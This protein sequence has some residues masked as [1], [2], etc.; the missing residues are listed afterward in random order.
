MPS[1]LG[2]KIRKCRTGLEM[3]L[4]DLARVTETSKGY[5]W[6]LENRDKPN[7]SADKLT[8]IAAA[9]GVTTEFLL[10][11]GDRSPDEDVKDLA[12]FRRYQNLDAKAKERVRKL[13]DIW[14]D[15]K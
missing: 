8:R 6:E 5:L 14:D 10:D 9:L 3:S 1:P 12:F 13:V 15:E 4:D 11:S 7:P 2:L